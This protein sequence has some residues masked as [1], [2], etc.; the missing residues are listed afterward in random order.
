MVQSVFT[1]IDGKITGIQ[2]KYYNQKACKW[3]G[4]Y[5]TPEQSHQLYCCKVHKK[6]SKQEYSRKRTYEHRK[7]YK[8]VLPKTVGTRAI[9][10]HR[11]ECFEEEQRVVAKELRVL[12]LH[13]KH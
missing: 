5:F 10:G 1:I 4:K 11:R 2:K 8:D 12:G 13:R 9:G 7:K 6:Y 3:C